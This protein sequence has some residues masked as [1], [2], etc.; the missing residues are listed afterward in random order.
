MPL[1]HLVFFRDYKQKRK[2][3]LSKPLMNCSVED[4]GKEYPYAMRIK[5]KSDAKPLK[6]KDGVSFLDDQ[7]HR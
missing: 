3:R 5:F 2:D 1:R 4:L 6:I 7:G